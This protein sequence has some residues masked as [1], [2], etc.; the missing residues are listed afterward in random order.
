MKR[1]VTLLLSCLL[2]AGCVAQRQEKEPKPCPRC[3]FIEEH[4]RAAESFM[5]GYWV[6]QQTQGLEPVVDERG[7][8]VNTPEYREHRRWLDVRDALDRAEGKVKDE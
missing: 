8:V 7:E 5:P 3:T 6:R 4:I 2:I 1:V